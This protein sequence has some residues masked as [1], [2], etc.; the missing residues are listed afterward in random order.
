[1]TPERQALAMA[2]LVV[3]TIDA[4]APGYRKL[5][6]S[7]LRCAVELLDEEIARELRVLEIVELARD[8][9]LAELDA[10]DGLA[11]LCVPWE[12]IVLEAVALLDQPR[13]TCL[14]CG[15]RLSRRRR[16][17]GRCREPAPRR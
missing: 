7:H 15:A 9:R 13:R 2:H 6:R 5:R 3:A 4:E 17:C 10:D 16:V 11:A 1:V 8:A 14:R 12:D